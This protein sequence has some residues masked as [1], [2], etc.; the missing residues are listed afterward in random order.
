MGLVRSVG[1]ECV[2]RK[3]KG[4]GGEGGRGMGLSLSLFICTVEGGRG[5]R[6]C[7]RILAACVLA[8]A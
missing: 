3:L 7:I 8:R 4:G 2:S 1:R 5:V 6:A